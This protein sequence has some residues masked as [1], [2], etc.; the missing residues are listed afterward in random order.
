MNSLLAAM[1]TIAATISPVTPAPSL[2]WQ[3]CQDNPQVECA[4][5]RVPIDWARPDGDTVD[6]A[7]AR[8]KATDPA[9]RVGALVYAP[10]GPGSSG[11]EAMTNTNY[12][13]MI[14]SPEAATRF[15][16]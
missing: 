14:I 12:F 15:D 6:I 10:A 1:V 4:T 16:V 9:H 11:V 7:V 13:N 2:D 3:P 5:L 8:R